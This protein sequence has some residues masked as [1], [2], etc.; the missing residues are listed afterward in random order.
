VHGLPTRRLARQRVI[1]HLGQ[2]L[3]ELLHLGPGRPLSGRGAIVTTP[4][5]T[6]EEHAELEELRDTISVDQLT[7]DPEA[8][9]TAHRGFH[10][11]LVDRLGAHLLRAVKLN[12]DSSER[13]RLLVAR[14]GDQDRRWQNTVTEH[15]ATVDAVLAGD[16]EQASQ[17]LSAHLARTALTLIAELAPAYDPS[18]LRAS[19]ALFDS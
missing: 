5:L 3:V 2:R 9:Q 6:A 15:A 17:L 1:L 4:R 11:L 12:M 14:L 7:H 13:Y 16:A 10:L 18:T 8:W 19:L